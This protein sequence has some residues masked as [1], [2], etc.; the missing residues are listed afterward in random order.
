MTQ[1]NPLCT[2][3]FSLI[4]ISI[5]SHTHWQTE[6]TNHYL[7]IWHMIYWTIPNPLQLGSTHHGS[8]FF[9]VQNK[10]SMAYFFHIYIPNMHFGMM[11]QNRL[12][13]IRSVEINM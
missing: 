7:N 13:T 2:I 5:P 1:S 6:V 12:F 9:A 3:S 4:G 10:I 11:F 8:Q